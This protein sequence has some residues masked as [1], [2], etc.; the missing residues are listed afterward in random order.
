MYHPV[1]GGPAQPS[2]VSRVNSELRAEEDRIG[3][4][5][6]DRLLL[7]T[8]RSGSTSAELSRAS[9]LTAAEFLLGLRTAV[10][11]RWLISVDDGARYLLTDAGRERRPLPE[12]TRALAAERLERAVGSA[13]M[14][15]A[16]EL[17]RGT[18]IVV[19]RYGGRSGETTTY[20]TAQLRWAV[21]WGVGGSTPVAGF[22][23]NEDGERVGLAGQYTG[24]TLL[25]PRLPR[26]PDTSQLIAAAMELPAVVR[27]MGPRG[28][29]YAGC[30]AV[31]TREARLALR[32]GLGRAPRT[33][34]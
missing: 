26:K 21:Q 11:R 16:D 7:V 10:A 33:L 25:H 18:A 9:G 6:A 19:R 8:S 1:D 14:K 24:P 2:W 22:V 27:A 4:A 31:A 5:L 17:P 12:I 15:L 3:P 23:R 29:G 28:H 20:T 13:C 30:V 34:Q 32:L